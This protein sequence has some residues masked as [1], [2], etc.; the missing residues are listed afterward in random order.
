MRD[1]N[2]KLVTVHPG[3]VK[4]NIVNNGRHLNAITGNVAD[5]AKTADIFNHS[6]ATTSGKAA[7]VII[8]GMRKFKARVL[9]GSD[10]K[11]LDV[12]QRI[13]PSCYNRLLVP[14]MSAGIRM[15]LKRI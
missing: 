8:H 9:I 4:T 7:A 5:V 10:A 15:V 2:V 6:A 11:L 3:S 14:L 12:I 13:F 1:T